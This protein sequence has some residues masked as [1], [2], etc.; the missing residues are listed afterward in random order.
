M[1]AY[2]TVDEYILNAQF[3][4]EILI[5][6]REI[7]CSTE[8]TETVKWG[9]PVYTIN[10]KNVVGLGSFKSYAGMWFYQGVFLNDEASVLINAQEGTT[11]AL[12]QWRFTTVDEI[13]EKLVLQYVGEAIQNAK[14]GKELKPDRDKK[15]VITEELQAAFDN[16]K[17]LENAFLGFTPGCKREFAG[18]VAEAKRTETRKSRVLKIIPMILEKRGLNDKYKK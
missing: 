7:L 6:L 4:R 9:G 5:V 17:N 12:R 10:D 15:L 16:D 13:D 3:G 18:Y 8:L 2:K 1:K 14:N 11:K